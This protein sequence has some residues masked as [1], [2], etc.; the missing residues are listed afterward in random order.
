MGRALITAP[1][2][3]P[4]TLA[5]AKAHLRVTDAGE[6]TLISALIAAARGYCQKETGRALLTQTWEITLDAFPSAIELPNPPV[7]SITSVK[8]LDGN[9]IE[10]TLD[11]AAWKLDKSSDYGVGRLV[12]AYGYVW[13]ATRADINA[14]RV[15]YVAGYADAAS[16]PQEMKQWM[17]LQ[18]GHWYEHRESINVGNITGKLDYV[19]GLLDAFRIF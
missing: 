13:P 12:P 19:D 8:Y 1:T 5:E 7:A 17:L 4:I 11:S 2:V 15:R 9:G 18:I 16:V 10:Q 6:D 3:E 14:V